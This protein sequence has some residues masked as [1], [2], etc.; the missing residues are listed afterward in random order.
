MMR[1]HYMTI[2]FDHTRNA[3][4]IGKIFSLTWNCYS[5]LVSRQGL[6]LGQQQADRQDKR[7]RKYHS[8]SFIKVAVQLDGGKTRS[9]PD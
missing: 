1:Y 8:L 2:G 9:L 7:G 6:S 3:M 5:T 4:P